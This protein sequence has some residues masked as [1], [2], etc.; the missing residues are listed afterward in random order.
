MWWEFKPKHKFRMLD[1]KFS[2][3]PMSLLG[4]SLFV[5]SR[6]SVQA[7]VFTVE[8]GERGPS[9]L[10]YGAQEW[11]IDSTAGDASVD[12]ISVGAVTKTL[13]TATAT[14]V[15][16]H[17]NGKGAVTFMYAHVAREGTT[18]SAAAAAV[19]TFNVTFEALEGWQFLSKHVSLFVP[20][21]STT[22]QHVGAVTLFN[23][24]AI[25]CTGTGWNNTYTGNN[26]IKVARCNVRIVPA[27]ATRT[28][29]RHTPASCA[30][31][32]VRHWPRLRLR[33][34]LSHTITTH[35]YHTPP[36][37]STY[38]PREPPPEM[39][40]GR[41]HCRLINQTRLNLSHTAPY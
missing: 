41:R 20:F 16:T 31:L 26:I 24:T 19:P 10:K 33:A 4:L 14:F 6:C 12:I 11:A 21:S 23:N 36:K 2:T 5:I 29:T 13:S 7:S 37:C 27:H 39:L 38:P 17:D 9:S 25:R 34:S 32:C 15:G 18:Q 8:Y 30:Y 35:H 1:Q 22:L 28:P 3:A 40:E